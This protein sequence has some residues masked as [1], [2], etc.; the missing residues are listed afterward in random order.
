MCDSEKWTRDEGWTR[1]T[2]YRWGWHL[3]FSAAILSRQEDRYGALLTTGLTWKQRERDW[4]A[5]S[6]ASGKY[7]LYDCQNAWIVESTTWF[8]LSPNYEWHH[9]GLQIIALSV[10]GC[11]F[12]FEV[13]R[14]AWCRVV[15][16][17]HA[18][19]SIMFGM[20]CMQLIQLA[21]LWTYAHIWNKLW[22]LHNNWH[23]VE[24]T[25]KLC[26]ICKG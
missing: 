3:K 16:R 24:G 19:S 13:I 22:L 25:S 18:H 14:I 8:S 20:L 26:A 11:V 1:F 21:V 6:V 5:T 9:L 7:K 23:F 10:I 17:V 2:A 4:Q 12:S 15:M